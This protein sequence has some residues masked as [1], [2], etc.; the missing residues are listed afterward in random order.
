MGGTT[1]KPR[2]LLYK[3]DLRGKLP[4]LPRRVVEREVERL[5]HQVESD[6]T[7]APKSMA[8]QARMS[9]WRLAH[10][11]AGLEKE[12]N[13]IRSASEVSDGLGWRTSKW[14]IAHYFLDKADEMVAAVERK[15]NPSLYD[16]FESAMRHIEKILDK[17]FFV[18]K[19]ENAVWNDYIRAEVVIT[20]CAH[21]CEVELMQMEDALTLYGERLM[22]TDG[23][24]YPKNF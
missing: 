21:L 6:T 10:I 24:Q 16:L 13:F 1:E 19:S 12:E 4:P 11:R 2:S 8:H 20:A 3:P 9:L 14:A 7:T 5:R 15:K 23:L 18:D 17:S 22:Q